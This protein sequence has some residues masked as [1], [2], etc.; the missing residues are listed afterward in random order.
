ME[1]ID[2]HGII[3]PLLL[4]H[5]LELFY[6]GHLLFDVESILICHLLDGCIIVI[7]LP[8]NLITQSSN[9][10]VLVV[11][12]VLS[13]LEQSL[14]CAP[15]G[16]KLVKLGIINYLFLEALALLLLDAY[17]LG[18]K[19]KV[20]CPPV[21]GSL[22]IPAIL[23]TLVSSLSMLA[24]SSFASTLRHLFVDLVVVAVPGLI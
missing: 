23:A 20:L 4:E 9:G 2:S 11:V 22:M 13:L 10:S 1:V 8:F 17:P 7:P 21:H 24:L 15:L 3:L 5:I 16:L 12:D 14:H 18:L 19:V 6:V